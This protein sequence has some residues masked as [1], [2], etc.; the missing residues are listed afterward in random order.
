MSKTD[1][2]YSRETMMDSI[3]SFALRAWMWLHR[4][5]IVVVYGRGDTDET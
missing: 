2:L 4:Q 3:I 5:H 1:R